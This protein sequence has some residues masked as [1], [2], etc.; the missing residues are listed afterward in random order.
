MEIW[1]NYVWGEREKTSS[2]KD[3]SYKN[4][5][6]LWDVLLKIPIYTNYCNWFFHALLFNLK[7]HTVHTFKEERNEILKFNGRELS[8]H[9]TKGW[10][11]IMR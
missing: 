1:G 8:V 5:K 7:I 4:G 3:R 6:V 2:W 10:N 11:E 9:L